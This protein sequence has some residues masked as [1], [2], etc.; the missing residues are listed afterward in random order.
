MKYIAFMVSVGLLVTVASSAHFKDP[1]VCKNGSERPQDVIGDFVAALDERLVACLRSLE[2][3][4]IEITIAS[5]RKFST[6][7]NA[8]SSLKAAWKLLNVSDGKNLN[9]AGSA[10]L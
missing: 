8:S 10:I 3:Q 9:Y 7:P 1:S 2:D 4:E 5:T 6:W